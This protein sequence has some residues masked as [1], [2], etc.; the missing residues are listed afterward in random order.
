MTKQ[1]AL[2]LC[3]LCLHFEQHNTQQDIFP[4]L[5]TYHIMLPCVRTGQRGQGFPVRL[6]EKAD[7]PV[8]PPLMQG[9]TC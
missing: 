8:K 9:Y 1:I 3:T 4:Y 7:I 2:L 6:N 5:R